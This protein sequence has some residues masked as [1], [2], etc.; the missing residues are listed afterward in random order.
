MSWISVVGLALLC[1]TGI[2]VAGFVIGANALEKRI[3]NAQEAYD[4]GET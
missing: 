2:F 1:A 3:R 4:R